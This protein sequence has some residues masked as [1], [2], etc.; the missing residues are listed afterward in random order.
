MGC[1]SAVDPDGKEGRKDESA[2]FPAADFENLYGVVF[3][4]VHIF[5]MAKWLLVLSCEKLLTGLHDVCKVHH[6]STYVHV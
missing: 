1:S 5:S 2:L 4:L 6:E 3:E